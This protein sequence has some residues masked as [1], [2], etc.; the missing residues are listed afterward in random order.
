LLETHFK[1]DPGGIGRPLAVGSGVP[2]NK[3]VAGFF[4]IAAVVQGR[5]GLPCFI[6]GRI[7]RRIAEVLPLPS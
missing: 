4:Q 2:T 6:I 7:S 3:Y 5:D 1:S